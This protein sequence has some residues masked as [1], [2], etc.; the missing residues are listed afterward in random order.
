MDKNPNRDWYP[1]QADSYQEGFSNVIFMVPWLKPCHPISKLIS[2]RCH[3]SDFRMIQLEITN[4]DLIEIL[5][6]CF[7]LCSGLG[8]AIG[9]G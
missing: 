9:L 1:E 7:L 5:I 6:P 8:V 4:P 3:G 2:P